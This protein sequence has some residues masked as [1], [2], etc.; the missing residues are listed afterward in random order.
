MSEERL[1][2]EAQA[3]IDDTQ[4]RVARIMYENRMAFYVETDEDGDVCV[5]M[6]PEEYIASTRAH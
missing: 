3:R 1:D 5:M 6:V 2:E 4:E